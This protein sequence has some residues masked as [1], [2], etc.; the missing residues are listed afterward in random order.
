MTSDAHAELLP[1]RRADLTERDVGG[2]RLVYGREAGPHLLDP[3]SAAVF[4]ALD[5]TTPSAELVDDLADV[6]GRPIDEAARRL[7]A[8]L[9]DLRARGLLDG[10]APAGGCP[11]PASGW[12]YPVVPPS[13]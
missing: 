11:P 3:L 6:L 7:G 12:R 9:D 13:P 10:S 2:A 5:G 8:L 1:A 4:D